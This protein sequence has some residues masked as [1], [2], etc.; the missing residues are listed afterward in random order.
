MLLFLIQERGRVFMMLLIIYGCQRVLSSTLPF[1]PLLPNKKIFLATSAK[2]WKY[3]LQKYVS[4]LTRS[5]L[6]FI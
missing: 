6:L 2:L 5:K 1:F 4:S 3:L